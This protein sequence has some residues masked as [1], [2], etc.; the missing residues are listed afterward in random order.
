[1]RFWLLGIGLVLV[2]HLVVASLLSLAVALVFGWFETR[3]QRLDPLRRA[4]LLL[5]LVFLPSS[6][7][8]LCALGLVLPAWLLFEPR[9]TAETLGPVLRF[10]AVAG[11]ALVTA[12]ATNALSGVLRTRKLLRVF[13]RE[14]RALPGLALPA[15]RAPHLFPVAA[16]S[17]LWRPR[18]FFADRVLE[19][20]DGEELEAVV[21]HEL[22]HREANDNLKR[23]LLNASPD[24]LAFLGAGQR[25]RAS[26]LEAA[27]AVADRRACARVEP[28]VLAR[29][30]LKVAAL[31]PPGKTLDLA[32]ASLHREGGLA[33]RVRALVGAHEG[34]SPLSLP[35]G[36]GARPTRAA[37]F[38]AGGLLAL[39]LLLPAVHRALEAIVK[40]LA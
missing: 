29:A 39:G 33:A 12:R 16:L 26:F 5:V 37:L 7:G 25:L 36:A 13:E 20:L 4:P 15:V 31:L 40:L 1:M 18:L 6:A 14:G 22:A 32:M 8:L 11:I 2:V 23:L 35:V 34:R 19:A 9:S 24:P 3:L 28:L 27:E 17:G 38:L 21:G 30:L 10:L